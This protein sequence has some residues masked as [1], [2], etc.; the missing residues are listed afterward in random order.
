MADP[1]AQRKNPL[2]K[3]EGKSLMWVERGGTSYSAPDACEFAYG[4][5]D[6]G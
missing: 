3:I 6:S 5:S 4:T 1:D 2:G